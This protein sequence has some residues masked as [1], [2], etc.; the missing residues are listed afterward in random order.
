MLGIVHGVGVSVDQTE[1]SCC[2]LEAYI[3]IRH[4]V[5]QNVTGK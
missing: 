1:K 4:T 5:N 2:L 3:L